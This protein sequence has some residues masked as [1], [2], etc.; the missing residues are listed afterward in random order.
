MSIN[1]RGGLIL[2]KFV[3]AWEN[4]KKTRLIVIFLSVLT[5]GVFGSK[6]FLGKSPSSDQGDPDANPSPY[7]VSSPT[8]PGVPS[9]SVALQ[10]LAAV[11]HA[12]QM[13]RFVPHG[14]LAP[15]SSASAAD[16][17]TPLG[18]SPNSN[19]A[20]SSG[21]T[22]TSGRITSISA[23]GSTLYVAGADGGV[24][25]STDQGASWTPL[26][27]NQV[28]L[29]MG[30]IAVDPAD[31]NTIYAATGEGNNYG[32]RVYGEGVLKSSTDGG[33]TWTLEGNSTLAGVQ[34]YSILVDPANSKHLYLAA[35]TGLFQ[36]N[37]A[38]VSWVPTDLGVV[39]D[40]GVTDVAIDPKTP[41]TVY[42]GV[43]GA[44]IYKS[45]DSGATWTELT[46]S[47][48]ADHIGRISLALSSSNPNVLY[49]AFVSD[50]GK[51]S[52]LFTSKDAGATW[53]ALTGTPDYMT[54]PNSDTG[55]GE[56]MSC[57]AVDPND[58]NHV[59]VAGIHLMESTDGGATWSTIDTNPSLLMK[60]D[61]HAL[62]FDTQ[63]NLYVGNDGGIWKRTTDG[64]WKNL[65]SNLS[66]TQFYSGMSMSSDGTKILGG[67]QDTGT[68][69]YTGSP[70]W[71]GVRDGDGGFT[72]I[73]PTDANSMVAQYQW[74]DIQK[75][76][77]GGLS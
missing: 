54:Y 18:P 3:G 17:W 26:T 67:T 71:K 36:S 72:A 65:N 68:T 7:A 74:G 12:H 16:Q 4:M 41:G 2:R 62:T 24:W 48:P 61:F 44:G 13:K 21:H 39:S 33:T 6:Y 56:N 31:P 73:D 28:T 75:T 42:V 59:F 38:G 45:T 11:R 47:L 46:G 50:Q 70:T 55:Q 25:K 52:G 35:T 19:I 43:D 1:N 64:Q 9:K 69:L 14:Q 60:V 51:L 23:D 15:L 5:A 57:V 76:T 20:V 27:D 32:D 40:K 77:N 37:D 29:G 58:P 63:G 30:S 66:L 10:Y 22:I 8:D 34:S 53:I 49:A